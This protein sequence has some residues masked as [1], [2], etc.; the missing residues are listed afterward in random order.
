MTTFLL[1]VGVQKAGTSWLHSYLH[2]RPDCDL[3]FCKEY[4]IHDALTVPQ[5]AGF[6]RS[7]GLSV[8]LKPRTMRRRYF[9]RNTDRYYN[10]FARLLRR[11][12]IRLSGDIT[13]SYS[14]LEASTYR[15][16]ADELTRRGLR[17]CP[18]LLL[19][20]PIERII[21]SARMKLR[22]QNQRD[23]EAEIAHLL[24]IARQRPERIHIRSDYGHT[25]T[26]LDQAF[27]LENVVVEF[28]ETLFQPSTIQRLCHHLAI[29]YLEPDFATRVN[30]SATDTVL[31]EALYQSLGA[32]QRDSYRATADR[33]P[34]VDL[35]TLWPTASRWCAG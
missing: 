32:W 9:M 18:V 4:H 19:R 30:A 27:G 11:P 22:K 29:P 21:S 8:L 35:A 7:G 3:G 2:N 24:Q 34:G 28:Y 13:P 1:G 31:P 6:G 26:Q 20:D 14:C 25:L 23:H 12:G 5:L 15:S 16:I 10:Y 33:F 17:L